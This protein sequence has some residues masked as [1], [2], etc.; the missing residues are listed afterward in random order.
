MFCWGWVERC[1]GGGEERA[2]PALWANGKEVGEAWVSPV[3]ESGH[4]GGHPWPPSLS[5]PLPLSEVPHFFPG[6]EK[7]LPGTAKGVSEVRVKRITPTMVQGPS[8]SGANGRTRLLID[9]PHAT[10]AH[11]DATKLES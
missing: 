2:E 9:P 8:S 1:G 7:V 4:Q 10:H 6:Q 3:G 5:S 11:K